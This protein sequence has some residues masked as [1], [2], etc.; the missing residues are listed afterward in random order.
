MRR[1]I[2]AHV[3]IT[4]AT[5]LGQKNERF[6]T[7]T[8]LYGYLKM[9]DGGFQT[10][11]PYMH[12]SQFTA[13]TLVNMMDVYGIDR[14][15]ILQSLLSPQNEEVARAVERYPDRLT[16]AMVLEPVGDW[17]RQMRYW[18]SRGLTV[19]KYEMRA[20]TDP[21]CYP[22]I[23]YDD[24]RMMEMFAE[25]EQLGLTV[26][27][28]PAPV[29]FPVYRPEA[30]RKAVSAFPDLHFV[31]CHMGY[32]LPIDTPERLARWEQMLSVAALPNCWLDVSAMPDFFDGEGWP[33]PTALRLLKQ[34]KETVGPD[35]L[36]WGTDITGSLNRATYP[37][38]RDLF[39]RAQG[40]SEEDYDAL[41][42]GNAQ[43]AYHLAPK[44]DP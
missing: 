39:Y 30:L 34:A 32:P 18:R 2:D 20:Y 7:Q 13:D 5:A 33:Y 35:K 10:M 15:V 38:M 11:P 31:L 6:G 19:I 27:I 21:A 41:F 23:C 25:A 28:D 12:D 9:R 36:I 22:D 1:Y 26:T 40:M 8:C 24:P 17:R 4:P 14:A 42:C 29:D 43:A 44:P 3:H 37:Q 16:G